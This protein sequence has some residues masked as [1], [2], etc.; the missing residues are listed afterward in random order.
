MVLRK[1]DL[2]RFDGGFFVRIL[3]LNDWLQIPSD[4]D[5]LA[6]NVA[7]DDYRIPRY[8]QKQQVVLPLVLKRPPI[9]LALHVVRCT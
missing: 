8:S 3:T 2:T 7:V 6:M 5:S 1:M 9:Q 4:Y